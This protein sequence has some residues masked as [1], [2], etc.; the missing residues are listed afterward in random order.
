MFKSEIE[1]V[2]EYSSD[3]LELIRK[4]QKCGCFYCGKTFFSADFF[5]K[6]EWV[7]KPMEND[8][9]TALCPFCGI[10]AVLPDGAG[11]V[12]SNELLS[13]MKDYWFNEETGDLL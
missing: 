1:Q 2:H 3:N 12:L 9:N 5:D 11:Y 10:D 8:R 13:R 4:S 7:R 6:L